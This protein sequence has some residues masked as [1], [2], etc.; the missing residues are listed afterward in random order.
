[1]LRP[2]TESDVAAMRGWRNQPAN[3]EV[4]IHPHEISA[5]EHAAWWKRV[6]EDSTRRVLVFQYDGRP[7]GIVNFFDL[8]PGSRTG[9]WGFFLDNETTTAEGTAMMAWMQVMKD[10]TSY[11]FDE[12][13]LD[14]LEAEVLEDNE[15]VRQMNRRLRFTEGEPETHEDG[16]VFYPITLRREDR[17]QPK[18]GQP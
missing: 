18:R 10:A 12:L 9:S 11:A 8:D 7:L 4:S 5:E 2:A 17:R 1:M 3:R 6:R 14:V 15:A 16:R 13:D